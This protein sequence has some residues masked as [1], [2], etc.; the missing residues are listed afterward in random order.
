MALSFTSTFLPVFLTQSNLESNV[1]SISP[2]PIESSKQEHPW[3]PLFATGTLTYFAS[4]CFTAH[5]GKK[6]ELESNRESFQLYKDSL[7]ADN[8]HALTLPNYQ[9]KLKLVS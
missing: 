3:F 8:S 1:G 9:S 6:Y 2:T 7:E 4:A 5:F